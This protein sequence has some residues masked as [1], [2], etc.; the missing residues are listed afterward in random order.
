MI[1]TDEQKFQFYLTAFAGIVCTGYDH[2]CGGIHPSAYENAIYSANMMIS[3]IQN[4]PRDTGS[5]PS[6]IADDEDNWE[7]ESRRRRY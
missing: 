4:L 3:E 1:L 5:N 7:D 6:Q 2:A